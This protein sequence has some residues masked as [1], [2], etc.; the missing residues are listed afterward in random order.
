VRIWPDPVL[1]QKANP[2][3]EVNDDVRSLVRDLWDTMYHENGIGLAA[4]Q[5]AVLQRVLVIDLDPR[6]ESQ[7]DDEFAE[8]L[9]AWGFTAPTAFIN[10][11]IVSGDGSIVFEEGCLSVPGISE[12]VTRKAHVVVEALNEK[13][14]PFRLEARGL[15]AVAIQ[16]ENDHLDGKVF[17]EYLSKLKRDIIRRKMERLIAE[18]D[19]ET[20]S[21]T[22]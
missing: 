20:A 17:V 22:G 8:E 6:G 16:H 5:V 7:A 18:R 13:G 12:E 9:A 1:K 3:A 15:F 10:P 19:Q 11:R 2:V 4:N 14:E 21:A